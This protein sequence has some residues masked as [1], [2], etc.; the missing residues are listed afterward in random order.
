MIDEINQSLKAYQAKWQE[1]VSNRKNKAFFKDL[2][3][4]AIAWKTVDLADFDTRFKELRDLCDKVHLGWVNDRWLATLNL[5]NT[6]LEWD[7][8]VIKLMQRRPGSDD[9]I[10]LDHVDFYAKTIDETV[11]KQEPDLKWTTESNNPH[12]S[13]LSIWF[14]GTEAKIRTDTVLDVCIAELQDASKAIVDK[15]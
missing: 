15:A 11:L 1:L 12:C 14:T 4:T 2:L 10:G 3:P 6:N 9:P 5:K 7:I 8:Q 13:W